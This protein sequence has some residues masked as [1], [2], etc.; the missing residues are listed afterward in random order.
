MCLDVGVT[1]ED[2]ISIKFFLTP[3]DPLN[4]PDPDI[5][6][7]TVLTAEESGSSNHFTSTSIH[8][9]GQYG[10]DNVTIQ[11]LEVVRVDL[12]RNAILI[13]GAIPGPKGS[14]VT[15]ADSIKSK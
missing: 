13:K 11:N 9:A 12:E 1:M 4:Q 14:I 2:A 10:V 5:A 7:S 3:V 15:I 8:L 6:L